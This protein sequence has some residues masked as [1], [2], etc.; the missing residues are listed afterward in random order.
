MQPDPNSMTPRSGREQVRQRTRKLVLGLSHLFAAA[1]ILNLA[2]C[3]KP[4]GDQPPA[5]PSGGPPPPQE[6]SVVT[7]ALQKVTLTTDLPG[8]TSPYRIADV[9]PQV[10][11]ILQKRMFTE[12]DQ[13]QEG[14]QLYQI[15]PAPYQAAY[16]SAQAT[17]DHAQ[18]EVTSA[19]FL[20]DRDKGL[21]ASNAVSKQD[22]DN[23]VA[24]LLQAKADVASG[25]AAVETAHVNLVY[26]KVLSPI[27]GI[28]GR[29]VTEGALVTTNQTSPLVTVQQLDPI[30]VD[31]PESTAILLRLR[32]ELASGQIQT[33]GDN[34]ASVTLTLEDASE[35]DM[36]GRLQ[37]S[38]VTVDQGTGSVILRAV[39]PNPKKI[40]L[41]GMFVT[42]HLE[43][44]FVDNGILVP[45]QGVT[46]D[47]RGQATALVVNQDNKVELRT[48]TTS[49]AIGDKWL[50]TD[51]VQAGDRVIVEG[52]QKVHPGATVKP[53]DVT[54]DAI[55]TAQQP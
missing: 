30:Y 4:A 45:Q 38:E 40:L 16:D 21:V 12:G 32:R 1:V 47:P 19:Q 3:Q 9:R 31:I 6:V 17:L 2:G 49:R 41:P 10:N 5:G 48:L 26:T 13:V 37:F 53:K 50:V 44:G 24:A 52:L 46:H 43:E 11:G 36:Q 35:Y 23:A 51:G 8:R 27:T 18:A 28:T 54:S 14:Q 55:P 42:A 22:Y 39:F 7:L 25:N 29:S 33:N 20:A 15:D 34:Q